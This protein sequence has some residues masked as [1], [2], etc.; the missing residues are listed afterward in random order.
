MSN[1]RN[2]CKYYKDL[3]H[4]NKALD[5]LQTKIS[6][7]DWK[8]F[9]EL[10]R[11]SPTSETSDILLPV[12]YQ[13][14]RVNRQDFYRICNSVVSF[15]AIRYFF[16]NTALTLNNYINIVN[17]YGDTTSNT[18][19]TLAMK[20]V[21]L[22]SSFHTNFSFA[23]LNLELEQKRP[24]ALGI[25]HR[26][27][28]NSPTGGGHWILCIGVTKDRQTYICHDPWGNINT[29]YSDTNGESVRISRRTLQARWQVHGA[30]NGWVHRYRNQPPR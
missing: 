27:T 12:R 19:Q 26:G 6:E 15:M 1:L 10:W 5:F 21:G 9:L 16:P 18:A 7:N 28:V 17:K 20:E 2:V 13:T 14:Q 24:V 11:K 29:G 8:Q 4:Q 30:S 25:L 3:E 23:D 22:Q